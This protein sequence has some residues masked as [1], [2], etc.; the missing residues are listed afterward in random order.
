MAP[1][2]QTVPVE[3]LFMVTHPDPSSFLL[4]FPKALSLALYYS[5]FLLM[6]SLPSLLAR[7]CLALATLNYLPLLRLRWPVLS[8]SPT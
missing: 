1:I 6:T 7:V 3:F 4:M 5:Y 2:Y 8:C